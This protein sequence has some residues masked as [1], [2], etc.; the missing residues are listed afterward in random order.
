[1]RILSYISYVSFILYIKNKNK[2]KYSD[3][4]YSLGNLKKKTQW[5]YLQ[6]R[7]LKLG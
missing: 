4:I 5:L 2:K 6:L 3:Y 7:Q 1:M